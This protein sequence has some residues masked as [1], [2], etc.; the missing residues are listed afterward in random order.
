MSSLLILELNR[1]L[2]LQKHC[3]TVLKDKLYFESNL[4]ARYI[5]DLIII[6]K[7]SGKT[8]DLIYMWFMNG[9]ELS[10]L[11]SNFIAINKTIENL[12]LLQTLVHKLCDIELENYASDGTIADTVIMS[13]SE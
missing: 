3:L 4:S 2:E 11:R 1:L 9:G 5:K 6:T 8:L 7:N 12:N 10:E 13:D